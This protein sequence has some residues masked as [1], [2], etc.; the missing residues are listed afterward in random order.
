MHQKIQNPLIYLYFINLSM[1]FNLMNL[2]LI[3]IFLIYHF[4]KKNLIFLI[5]QYQY[6]LFLIFNFHL[7][8]IKFP[9]I[10]TK[11]LFFTLL[12]II[13]KISLLS[14]MVFFLLFFNH[15]K[16]SLFFFSFFQEICS[17]K[18]QKFYFDIFLYYF[19]TN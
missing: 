19:T 12:I 16:F 3:I 11:S 13:F 10:F 15:R 8:F 18:H 2:F 5:P 14:L 4:L 17:Q 9:L 6:Q 7:F 1:A